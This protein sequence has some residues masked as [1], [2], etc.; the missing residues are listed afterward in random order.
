M[1]YVLPFTILYVSLANTMFR[2]FTFS[3]SAV[4]LDPTLMCFAY[5]TQILL[6]YPTLALY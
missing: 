4:P 3:D 1:F 2:Y 6:S 5:H